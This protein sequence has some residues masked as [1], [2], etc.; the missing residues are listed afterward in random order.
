M[1]DD[2]LPSQIATRPMR[3]PVNRAVGGPQP[4]NAAL[5]HDREAESEK[6]RGPIPISG[7]WPL[8]IL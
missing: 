2:T 1:T 4:T 7:C 3:F 6:R 8:S 5:A